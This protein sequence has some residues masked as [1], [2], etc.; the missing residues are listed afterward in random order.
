[1][2]TC[3]PPQ[4]TEEL[5]PQTQVQIPAAADTAAGTS[6]TSPAQK[7]RQQRRHARAE[8]WTSALPV[9]AI[10]LAYLFG[11]GGGFGVMLADW[12]YTQSLVANHIALLSL[13]SDI[14]SAGGNVVS[15]PSHCRPLAGPTFRCTS[16]LLLVYLV[17][18]QTT[19]DKRGMRGPPPTRRSASSGNR[20]PAVLDAARGVCIRQERKRQ[21]QRRPG[22]VQACS[23]GTSDNGAVVDCGLGL[24]LHCVGGRALADLPHYT[25]S[26]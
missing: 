20:A 26:S 1:M 15:I 16:I 8:R 10:L 7:R 22:R 23:Q 5:Q 19:Q 24:Y 13:C 12:A 14:S 4:P 2:S 6:H 18:T 3:I 9:V 25:S 21:R 17:T 11:L